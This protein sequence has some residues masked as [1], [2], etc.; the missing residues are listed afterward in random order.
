ML[1][2]EHDKIVVISI[3]NILWENV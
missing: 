2:I 3:E 1:Y